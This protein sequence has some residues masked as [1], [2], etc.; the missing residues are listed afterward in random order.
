MLAILVL[1]VLPL[2]TC[3]LCLEL[4]AIFKLQNVCDR[5]HK[6]GLCSIKHEYKLSVKFGWNIL[7]KL[8]G[9]SI[10]QLIK[11]AACAMF[12]FMTTL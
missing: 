9:F 11:F 3:I 8:C 2:T 12:L 5:Y 10:F 4:T 6:L 1:I 7:T